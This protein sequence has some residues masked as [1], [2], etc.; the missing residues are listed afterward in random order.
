MI[1]SVL[2]VCVGNICRSPMAETLLRE[3]LKGRNIEVSSAG[4][5]ALVGRPM[6]STAQEVLRENGF[7]LSTHKARQVDAEMLRKADLILTM[8]EFHSRSV[9]SMAPEIKGRV[10]LIGKWVNNREVPDPY[11]LSKEMFK[12]VHILLA[13]CVDSWLPY[14]R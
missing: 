3:G 7:E 6:D 4:I 14:I 8:E 9:E 2:V 13:K 5:G 11:R 1:K 10:F 12:E